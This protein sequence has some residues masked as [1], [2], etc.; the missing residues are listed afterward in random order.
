MSG[1]PATTEP[2]VPPS[3]WP[4]PLETAAV[5]ALIVVA[6]G[7]VEYYY[8]FFPVPPGV[9]PGDWIQRSYGWVGLPHPPAYSVGSPFLYAPMLFPIL[10]GLRL[11][12]GSPLDTGFAFGG[13]VL[14]AYGFSLWFLARTVLV[15]PA[16][17]VGFVGLGLLN[18]T[19]VSM[20][21]W[22]GYPN[23]LAFC[24]LDVA[25]GSLVLFLQTPTVVRGIALGSASAATYLTH[26]LT[27]DLLL[28]TLVL[29]FLGA[30][31]LRRVAWRDLIS[32]GSLFVVGLPAITAAGYLAITSALHIPHIDYLYSDPPAFTLS[33]LGTLFDPLARSPTYAPAGPAL[34]LS[35]SA[36]AAILGAAALLVIGLV[37][38]GVRSWPARWGVPVLV[39]GA[40][41]AIV[42][43]A[44][45]GGYAAHVATDYSRFVYFLPVPLAL[46]AIVG[47]E[48]ALP[49]EL[50]STAPPHDV[51]GLASARSRFRVLRPRPF[52]ILS[53]GLVA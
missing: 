22:G 6:I 27:F 35:A 33:G 25:I 51:P 4:D 31:L 42:L 36:T 23:F 46:L 43:L 7:L 44:P 14:G 3:R 38:W 45:I 49:R 53:I 41:S 13:L 16:F 48:G 5:L 37:A 20:L 40:W 19:V 11:A 12:T 47:M 50:V 28:G 10:G 52:R 24:F 26:A 18:G 1:A 30:L 39:G 32:T 2:T 15:V 8:S 9:D 34:V 29:A 17:R 21:F